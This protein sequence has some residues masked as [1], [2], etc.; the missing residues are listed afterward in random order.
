MQLQRNLEFLKGKTVM[1]TAIHDDFILTKR[2][3]LAMAKES[4][5][6][7]WPV[8][9]AFPKMSSLT[10]IYDKEFVALLF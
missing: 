3:R 8:A 2:C 4:L 6:E 9:L 10:K 1:K 7:Y 5:S